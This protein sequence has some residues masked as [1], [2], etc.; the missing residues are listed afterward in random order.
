MSGPCSH[1]TR[2]H[3][4][5]SL[6]FTRMMARAP[7]SETQLEG[8]NKEDDTPPAQAA[9][10]L[11][12][13]DLVCVLERVGASS[14]DVV[15]TSFFQRDIM[16]MPVVGRARAGVFIDRHPP[17]GSIP[18]RSSPF[19]YPDDPVA[20]VGVHTTSALCTVPE[21][22]HSHF[23]SVMDDNQIVSAVHVNVTGGIAYTSLF[24]IRDPLNIREPL[25]AACAAL[26][27]VGIRSEDVVV[28]MIYV[29][30]TDS[31]DASSNARN[32]REAVATFFR[33]GEGL[34]VLCVTPPVECVID[35]NTIKGESTES[36]ECPIGLQLIAAP[37]P[38]VDSDGSA[39]GESLY[40]E[41]GTVALVKQPQSIIFTGTLASLDQN[42]GV[43]SD[44]VEEQVAYTLQLLHNVLDD[45]GT[46][47]D[48]I[49]AVNLYVV[50]A[51]HH[52]AQILKLVRA[53]FKPDRC[54][55]F[56]VVGISPLLLPRL[57]F[58]LCVVAATVE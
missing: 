43:T 29:G 20:L 28:A 22:P 41:N 57:H 56:S 31:D 52:A 21:S 30:S 42:F 18:A 33:R 48:H 3:A 58:E 55:A 4:V 25:S 7:S 32:A 16:A 54:P 39:R 5:S 17:S 2:A 15:S 26:D 9:T 50:D 53:A 14:Q 44:R 51:K 35:L 8:E 40:H 13:Q 19:F 36:F 45:V 47:F 12:L 27:A 38:I 6:V 37:T 24:A 11:L 10:T 46:S 23:V 1:V 34:Q 49:I